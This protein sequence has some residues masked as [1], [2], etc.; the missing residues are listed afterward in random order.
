MAESYRSIFRQK[1][2]EK[3]YKIEKGWS[4][5]R[6]TGYLKEFAGILIK[7][8][9][10]CTCDVEIP[11][12]EPGEQ[13]FLADIQKEVIIKSRMRSSDGSIVYYVEDELVDTENTEMTLRECNEMFSENKILEDNYDKLREKFENYTKEY[14][15]KHRW[16]NFF[17]D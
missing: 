12:L 13:F 3:L 6:D 15:Y 1:Y 2:C 16:L 11:M 9:I 5:L 14:K 7:E 8:E 17:L 4:S 10:I